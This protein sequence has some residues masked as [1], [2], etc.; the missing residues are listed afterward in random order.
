M[1]VSTKLLVLLLISSLAVLGLFLVGEWGNRHAIS[2]LTILITVIITYAIAGFALSR[3]WH[4]A[5]LISGSKSAELA[6][7]R[8]IEERTRALLQEID[9]RKRAEHLNRGQKHVLEML[10]D[11]GD[12]TTEEILKALADVVASRDQGWECSIYLVERRG[13]IM[14]LAASSSVHERMAD[15]FNTVGKDYPDT[16]ECQAAFS[17]E[18]HV[19][20]HLSQVDVPWS[21]MLVG[22][23][24]FSACSLPFCS[25]TSGRLTGV[26]TVY[27]RGRSAAD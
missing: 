6:M 23:G 14:T 3:W 16:P 7:E 25:T 2:P 18:M 13:R 21:R 17:G 20:E 5:D 19:V 12:L 8:R 1:R 9:E 22:N 4:S 15:Y 26:L 24:I 27:S 11:P 10:A